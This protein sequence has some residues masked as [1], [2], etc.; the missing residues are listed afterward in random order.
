MGSSNWVLQEI[1]NTI[2]S[3]LPFYDNEIIMDVS[4]MLI[5]EKIGQREFGQEKEKIV[6]HLLQKKEDL[7][8]DRNN[9]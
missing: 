3:F 9:I 6:G 8:E 7:K 4:Q 1:K 5:C 2:K